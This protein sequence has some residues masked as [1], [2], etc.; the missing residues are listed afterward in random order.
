MK[1]IPILM[2]VVLVVGAC[3]SSNKGRSYSNGNGTSL[4]T[5]TA[6]GPIRTECLASSRKARSREL[7]GCVQAAADRTLTAS[8]QTLAASFYRHPQRAQD[9]RQSDKARDEVFWKKYKNYSETA[10]AFC[11]A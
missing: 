3:S 4:V 6:N 2:A 7:C 11:S 1:L 9:I 10:A 5:R 8:D